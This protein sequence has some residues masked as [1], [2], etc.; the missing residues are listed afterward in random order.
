MRTWHWLILGALAYAAYR[1]WGKPPALDIEVG[2]VILNR[3]ADAFVRPGD[4]AGLTV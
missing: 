1:L 2:A 3:P 4:F